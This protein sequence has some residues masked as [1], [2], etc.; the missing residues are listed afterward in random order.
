MANRSRSSN[1]PFWQIISRFFLMGLITLLLLE[2]LTRLLWW[3]PEQAIT[4]LG[5]QITLLP[6]PVLTERQR[7]TLAAWAND[8]Q[9]YVQFDPVLGWSHTP[10]VVEEFEGVI[11]TSNS[12][13][14][15]STHEYE[16]IPP[17][18]ILR[19]AAFGPS[20]THGDEVGDDQT[21]TAQIEQS[22]PN[23][24]VMNWGVGGYG[25]DQAYLRYQTQGVNYQPHIV[26]IGFEEENLFRNVNRFRPFYRNDTGLPL[27][28]PVF[29]FEGEQLKLLKNPF[30][31][32]DTFYDTITNRPDEF[33]EIVCPD[34]FF[35]D[36]SRYHSHPLDILATYRFFRTLIFEITHNPQ[37]LQE[38][39]YP[40]EVT[41]QVVQ[42]FLNE[43]NRNG[44]IPLVLIFPEQSTLYKYE[45]GIL[46]P[47]QAG[48]VTL[49][50]QGVPVI[51]LA[52]ALTEA[53][54]AQ[55]LA[56]QDFYASEGGHFN[57]LGNQV[58]AQTIMW[59]LCGEGVLTDC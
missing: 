41:L 14:V 21:W 57:A 45:Q 40:T 22:R 49:R 11:Y 42:R 13:G 8:T 28:K 15:R 18:G 19:L 29:I 20:F 52:G 59:H 47:Y 6:W 30:D 54:Q 25:T 5:R 51:D 16:P 9:H 55:S 7:E 43:I 23:V 33:L 44:A 32:F 37:E 39:P 24:E 50:D 2:G 26:I 1:R 56:Y 38:T 36:E 46:P 3:Q 27:T 48:M 17:P 31:E 10:G 58:V 12:S 35:C 34:D 4:L 53:K